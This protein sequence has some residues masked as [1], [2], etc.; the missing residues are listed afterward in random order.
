MTAAQDPR[1]HELPS[2]M[3]TTI[4]LTDC[5]RFEI[6]VPLYAEF[7]K[8]GTM[9]GTWPDVVRGHVMRYLNEFRERKPDRVIVC[10]THGLIDDCGGRSCVT[11]AH[12]RA[13]VSS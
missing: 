12:H 6:I 4:E 10:V 11:I 7:E 8:A 2:W 5:H 13:K 3:A 9:F 1:S